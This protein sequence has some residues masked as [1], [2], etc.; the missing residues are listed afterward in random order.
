MV[1]RLVVLN[2]YPVFRMVLDSL[3]PYRDIAEGMKCLKGT[4]PNQYQSQYNP[5]EAVAAG[6]AACMLIALHHLHEFKANPE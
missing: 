4:F 3:P 6:K 5:A 2:K 1:V